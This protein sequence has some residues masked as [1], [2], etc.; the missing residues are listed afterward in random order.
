MCGFSPPQIAT[1]R[2]RPI[3][4]TLAERSYSPSLVLIVKAVGL[5]LADKPGAEKGRVCPDD[6]A[7]SPFRQ[8]NKALPQEISATV[9]AGGIAGSQPG[10]ETFA[11]LRD[12]GE[13]GVEHRLVSLLGVVS[14]GHSFLM[15]VGAFRGG[16][17]IQ[18]DPGKPF[19]VPDLLAE[20]ALRL[21]QFDTLAK[22]ES[23][24]NPGYGRDHRET[25]PSPDLHDDR[26]ALELGQMGQMTT[27]ADYSQDDPTEN[28]PQRV[29]DVLT[30]LEVDPGLDGFLD[31]QSFHEPGYQ[32]QPGPTGQPPFGKA[33]RGCNRNSLITFSDFVCLSGHPSE[34]PL[35]S[36][37]FPDL[38]TGNLPES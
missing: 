15:A 31:T 27:T 21:G 3:R 38:L 7:P 20:P 16:I 13:E 11:G 1:S 10:M 24:K 12:K 33:A 28:H 36:G 34:V 19:L 17:Q 29:L 9:G 4:L 2:S 23:L 26:V 35:N 18:V 22:A 5:E 14:P 32:H 30:S 8:P 6:D 25:V 37:G